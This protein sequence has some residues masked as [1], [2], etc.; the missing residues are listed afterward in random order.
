MSD[1]LVIGYG[2]T[3]RR[4]DGAG[5]WVAQRVGELL[6]PQACCLAVPQLLPELAEAMAQAKCV[7]FVDARQDSSTVQ[8][9][10]LETGNAG[11]SSGS[12]ASDPAALAHLTSTLYGSPPVIWLV[13]VP[14]V[15][16]AHGEGLSPLTR[17]WAEM[18]VEKIVSARKAC[19][20]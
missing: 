14:A 9:R 12:H 13:T 8:M 5:P 3:L 19:T 2:N 15:E 20:P 16:F 18:A 6:G 17:H 10:M 11:H 1:F 4:D 7:V